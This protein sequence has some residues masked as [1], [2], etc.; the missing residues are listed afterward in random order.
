MPNSNIQN[1]CYDLTRGKLKLGGKLLTL[2]KQYPSCAVLVQS[3][4]DAHNNGKLRDY[5]DGIQG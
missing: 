5:F 4:T 1:M 2:N 3:S